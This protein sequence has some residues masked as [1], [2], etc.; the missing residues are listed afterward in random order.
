MPVEEDRTPATAATGGTRRILL[1]DDEAAVVQ[2]GQEMLQAL[3]YAV[4]A[5]T[6]PLEA[7]EVFR[8]APRRFDLV[9]TDQT[10]PVMT[11]DKLV[12]ELRRIRPDIPLILCTGYSHT[13]SEEQARATGVDA[14]LLK[15]LLAV[16]YDRAI[17]QVLKPSRRKRDP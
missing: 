14:Y 17:R 5:C 4:T 7:L 9:I 15:P 11:G 13:L 3:G 16:D 12:P 1:V 8:A 2:V 10:M 6:N